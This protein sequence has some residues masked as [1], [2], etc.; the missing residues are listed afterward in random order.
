ICGGSY[1][2]I[3]EEGIELGTAGN[4]YIKSNALQKM[5]AANLTAN[6]SIPTGCEIAIQEA[7]KQQKANVK[8]G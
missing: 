5:G 7:D 1:I 2:K 3:S 4:V 8:L 6:P